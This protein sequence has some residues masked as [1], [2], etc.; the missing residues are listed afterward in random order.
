MS[1]S[2]PPPADPP[3]REPA[4]A[5][6]GLVLDPGVRRLDQ[7]GRV[8][9]GGSP[10]RILRLAP[11]GAALLDRWVAGTPVAESL[12]QR[13]LARRLLDAGIAHPRPPQPDVTLGH[14]EVVAI[15]PVLGAPE[16]LRA[17][18]RGLAD[19][20]CGQIVVV[21][22]GSTAPEATWLDERA[23]EV[24]GVCVHAERNGGPA[25]ARQLGLAHAQR[26]LVLFVDA[27]AVAPDRDGLT[28]LRAHLAD[29]AVV[30]VAP[31]IVARLGQDPPSALERFEAAHLPLDLGGAEARV[32]P[33]TTVAYVPTAALLV[34]RDALEAVGGF[35]V[36]LRYGEDVDL[37]WRLVD[38]G[39][40]V[41]YEPAVQLG[42]EPRPTWRSW[43]SQRFR[44]GTAAAPLHRRHP[45]Q[46]PPLA[47]SGWS[48][49]AWVLAG[50]GWPLAGLAVAAGSAAALPRKLAGSVPDPRR[51]A[52]RLAGWG[53]GH[54]G[55]WVARAVTRTWWPFA[56]VAALGSRRARRAVVAAVAVPALA[57]W[58][59]RRAQ[60]GLD[61]VRYV[62]LRL[63]DDVAYGAG[64]W[65]GCVRHRTVG[66]LVADLTSWPGRRGAGDG[67]PGEASRGRDG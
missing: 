3:A 6:F 9:V 27:D 14:D 57:D 13:R 1:A 44:Y 53:H 45:G 30:A 61:P 31:R 36:A 19:A 56:L 50:L 67:E 34:R 63:A 33:R 41:R 59:S 26:P 51:E 66:P 32:V 64:V 2:G 46:V 5:G 10:L 16:G 11:A 39:G 42:H 4:P 21:D 25:A 22:D 47:V 62:A 55:R 12:A 17:T 23:A 49:A 60:I 52:L 54:A 35:D 43:L 40:V 28:R 24:G 37:I 20:G 8:L 38:A 15:V 48:L 18:L 7:G 65:A 58:W 29:P